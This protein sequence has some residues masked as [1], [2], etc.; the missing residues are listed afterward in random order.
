MFYIPCRHR[1]L[2]CD[3]RSWMLLR[4]C[5]RLS[6]G[7]EEDARVP[8][9]EPVLPVDACCHAYIRKLVHGCSTMRHAQRPHLHAAQSGCARNAIFHVSHGSASPPVAPLHARHNNQYVGASDFAYA[10]NRAAAATRCLHCATAILL[11]SGH[12]CKVWCLRL[13]CCYAAVKL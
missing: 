1:R 12:M 10:L 3:C 5:A 2:P 13:C 4:R 11:Q 7:Q 9:S 6:S 8:S